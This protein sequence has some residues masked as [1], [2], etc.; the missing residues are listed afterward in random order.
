[1]RKPGRRTHIQNAVHMQ[2]PVTLFSMFFAIVPAH[3][4]EDSIGPVVAGLLQQVDRVVVVDDGSL[5]A[6]AEAAQR[7][8]AFVLSHAVNRGQGAALETGHEYA[9]RAGAS[10]VLHFDADNQFDSADIVPALK[11]LKAAQA[12]VL[13][14]SRFLD[15]RSNVPWFKRAI[16]LPVGRIINRLFGTHRLSDAHNG[17]RILNRRALHAISIRHDRMAHATDI[18][19]Q[20]K[21]NDLSVIEFPVKVTYH[22]YGQRAGKGF[23]VVKDLMFGLFIK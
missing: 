9:R 6:T 18:P 8:G 10:F 7:A 21:Q 20:A 3:N 15:G 14:G 1:M 19:I 5:D 22:E 4:E 2:P 17:F 13:F 11:A 12:D 23:D 16:I